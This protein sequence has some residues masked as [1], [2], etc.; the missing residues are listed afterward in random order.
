MGRRYRRHLGAFQNAE[1]ENISFITHAV[2]FRVFFYDDFLVGCDL[3]KYQDSSEFPVSVAVFIS[4]CVSCSGFGRDRI[5]GDK[6][7]TVYSRLR[8]YRTFDGVH[9]VAEGISDS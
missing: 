6:R 4:L 3:G 7:K 8:S 9:V 1:N 2:A 5:T